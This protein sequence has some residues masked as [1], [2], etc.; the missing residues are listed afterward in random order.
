MAALQAL[1]PKLGH[2]VG[3]QVVALLQLLEAT[4]GVGF[5]HHC[6][7]LSPHCECI[8]ASQPAPPTSWS[9]IVRQAPGYGVTSSSRGVTDPSTSMGG[10]PVY[11]VPPPGLTPPD[12]FIWCIPP[13][14]TPSPP[15][16]LVSLQY[17]PSVGRASQMRAAIERQAQ[18]LQAQ[19]LQA[20]P[21][22]AP[23][24][25]APQVVPPLCQ[26]LPFP[27]SWSATPYKQAV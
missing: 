25:P 8:G 10:M 18:A 9:Q 23:L 2:D 7:N 12:F 13:Q 26:P 21:P 27:G 1:P 14:E 5:C 22:W 17:W 16:I 6:C 20:P 24:L 11:M 4:T 3:L 19:A 15:G